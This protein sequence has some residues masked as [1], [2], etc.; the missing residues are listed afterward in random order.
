VVTQNNPTGAAAPP[1]TKED[2][3]AAR[4]GF[5]MALRA[6]YMMPFGKAAAATGGDMSDSFTS[7]GELLLDVGAKIF[8]NVFLGG[9]VGIGLGGTSGQLTAM[10][11]D[12]DLSCSTRTMRGGV[13]V[14]Y[15][16]APRARYNP[17]VGYGLG[18]EESLYRAQSRVDGSTLNASLGGFE[19]AHLMAG[20]DVRLSKGIGIGPTVAFTAAQY[21]T[22]TSAY[23]NNG[24]SDPYLT[25]SGRITHQSIHEWFL[26]GVRLT[27]FP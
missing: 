8:K 5:Q 18:T 21:S 4:T 1:A 2:P 11:S 15:H 16:F 24:S 26:L 7:E 23:A 27:Y 13:E 10:C 6:G 14:Q 22:V 12:A 25:T 20:L 17:W 3:P 19:F 9:Y